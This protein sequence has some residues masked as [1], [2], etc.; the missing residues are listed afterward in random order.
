MVLLRAQGYGNNLC[1]KN[2]LMEKHI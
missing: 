1:S 2:R